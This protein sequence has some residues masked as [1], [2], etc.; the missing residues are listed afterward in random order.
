MATQSAHFLM[1]IVKILQILITRIGICS[2]QSRFRNFYKV[3][4]SS[5]SAISQYLNERIETFLDAFIF[6]LILRSVI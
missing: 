5:C 6:I 2:T 3:F 4:F 1:E